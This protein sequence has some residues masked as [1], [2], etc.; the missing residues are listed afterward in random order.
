MATPRPQLRNE[1]TPVPALTPGA[2]EAGGDPTLSLAAFTTARLLALS[3]LAAP[4]A[5]EGE[6][7]LRFQAGAETHVRES[8]LLVAL[9]APGLALARRRTRGHYAGGNLA[10]EADRFLRLDGSGELLLL[11]PH[12]R[13]R[14][15]ALAL[16]RDVLYIE[17]DRV[18]AWGDEVVWESGR[19]PGNGK[20]LLQ[21]RGSGRVVIVTG[22]N[23]LVAVR[24]SEGECR[25]VPTARLAGWL[26]QVVVQGGPAAAENP[27]P[28]LEYVTCEGEGV[29]LLSRHGESR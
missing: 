14:L 4:L 22:E 3:P 25:V 15:T 5:A 28:G 8:A 10:T 27:L 11:S 23:E 24:I 7:L 26:G 19:V 12:R 13:R 6:G 9:G 16:E 21:F 29:L 2:G 17:E 18:M 1:V 20:A